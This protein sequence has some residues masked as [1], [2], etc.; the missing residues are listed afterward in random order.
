MFVVGRPPI[1]SGYAR[2]SN[3]S[4][5]SSKTRLLALLG[6]FST[7]LWAIYWMSGT[8]G[9]CDQGQTPDCRWSRKLPPSLSAAAIVPMTGNSRGSIC[10]AWTWRE[11]AVPS[12]AVL[13]PPQFRGP[14]PQT[15]YRSPGQF[16]VSSQFRAQ[17]QFR[18]LAVHLS[19]FT[20]QVSKQISGSVTHT[21]FSRHGC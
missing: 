11:S 21:L 18:G 7:Y 13:D 6:N 1:A 9:T 3:T 19:P 12:T 20:T 15:V 5:A 8:W 16:R 2:H 17:R 14:V 4:N 10:N